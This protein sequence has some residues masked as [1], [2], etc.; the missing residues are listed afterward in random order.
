M[1]EINIKHEVK[2]FEIIC[3]YIEKAFYDLAHP[4]KLLFFRGER[5]WLPFT[6]VIALEDKVL[7][8]VELASVNKKE[9]QINFKYPYLLIKG[10]REEKFKEGNC[11]YHQMEIEYG[12]F[13][14]I[15]YIPFSVKEKDI[16]ARYEDG[17]LTIKL[18]KADR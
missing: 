3:S 14:R 9:I 13:E 1:D 11:L 2:Q 16:H 12:H 18:P 6:N 15:I 4:Q 5:G 17:L 8:E 10:C 7:V